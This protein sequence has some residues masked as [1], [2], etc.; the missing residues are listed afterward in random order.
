M[1]IYGIFDKKLEQ[2]RDILTAENDDLCKRVLYRILNGVDSSDYLAFPY[3]FSVYR[4]GSF[5]RK[6]GSIYTKDVK[7]IAFEMVS[8]FKRSA[9]PDSDELPFD[10]KE[11]EVKVDEIS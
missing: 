3:D 4:L 5:S 1:I 2:F 9:E 11:S 10:D 6:T 8:M 7:S